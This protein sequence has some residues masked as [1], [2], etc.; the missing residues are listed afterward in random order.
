MEQ[1]KQTNKYIFQV[2][3]LKVN[4]FKSK[5]VVS[6]T[7]QSNWTPN[8]QKTWSVIRIGIILPSCFLWSLYCCYFCIF[9][10]YFMP[11]HIEF[12]SCL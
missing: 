10:L 3:G 4:L 12:F 6:L 9:Y 1:N 2:F 5:K 7:E 8:M 11:L